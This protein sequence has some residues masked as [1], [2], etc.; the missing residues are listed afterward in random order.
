MDN[1]VEEDKNIDFK[2]LL[3]LIIPVCVGSICGIFLLKIIDE[4]IL[5]N[6]FYLFMV[7]IGFYEIFSSLKNIYKTKNNNFII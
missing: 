2:N 1:A 7:I 6:C 3:K 5:K 4:K